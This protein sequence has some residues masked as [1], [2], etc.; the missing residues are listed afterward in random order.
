[1]LDIRFAGMIKNF[2]AARKLAD[3]MHNLALFS[4]ND[5]EGFDEARFWHECSYLDRGGLASLRAIFDEELGDEG[6]SEV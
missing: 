5:F 1:M 3:A 4:A 2:E 6:A